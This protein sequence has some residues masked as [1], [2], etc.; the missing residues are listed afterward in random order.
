MRYLANTKYASVAF[1]MCTCNPPVLAQLRMLDVRL[2]YHIYTVLCLKTELQTWHEES[3]ICTNIL[4]LVQSYLARGQFRD[5]SSHRK[6][7]EIA[8]AGQRS[9]RRATAPQ[10]LPSISGHSR[11]SEEVLRQVG[12]IACRC[13]WN[14]CEGP[15]RLC[16]SAEQS[17]GS[18]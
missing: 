15:A 13:V 17:L 1:K 10:A 7:A 6:I 3:S 4:S 18:A 12:S 11:R 5:C 9:Q 2:Q 16:N 14:Q 8:C